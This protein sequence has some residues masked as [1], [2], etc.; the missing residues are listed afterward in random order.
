MKKQPIIDVRQVCWLVLCF[1]LA[2]VPLLLYGQQSVDSLEKVLATKKLTEK[3]R[4][5]T[6][7]DL[8]RKY[9]NLNT[10][11]SL[12]YAKLGLAL[13]RKVGDRKMEAHFY[14]NM[15]GAYTDL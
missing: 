7:N 13:A 3:E 9:S 14:Q 5:N 1:A 15:G 6:Y 4:I 8:A 12:N 11:K 2:S 10:Q